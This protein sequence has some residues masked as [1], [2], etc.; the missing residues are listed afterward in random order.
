MKRLSLILI[1]Q[2]SRKLQLQTLKIDDEG[3]K[4]TTSENKDQQ[5]ELNKWLKKPSITLKEKIIV[6]L[7]LFKQLKSFY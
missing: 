2:Q 1:L 3:E 6:M 4:S 7:K 5:E